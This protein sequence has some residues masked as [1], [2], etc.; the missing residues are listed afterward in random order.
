MLIIYYFNLK[1]KRFRN[2]ILFWWLSIFFITSIDLVYEFLNGQNILGFV[3]YM[4]GRLA[5]FFNDELIVGHFYYGFVLIVIFFLS[6]L[7]SKNELFKNLKKFNLNNSIYFFIFIFLLI[8]LIIGE[9]SNFIKVLIMV[10]LFT[11]LYEKRLFKFKIIFLLFFLIVTLLV[12][13]N[14]AFFIKIDSSIK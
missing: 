11:F 1:N 6:D 5:G 10:T 2:T 7:F 4:P 8:S 14:S 9:R 12:N 3:S 13:F